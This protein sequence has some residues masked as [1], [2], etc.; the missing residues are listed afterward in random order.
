HPAQGL[1]EET[2]GP[3]SWFWMDDTPDMCA[4]LMPLANAGQ[5]LSVVATVD[6]AYEL[7]PHRG[8][9]VAL[10]LFVVN[11]AVPQP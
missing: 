1:A 7:G 6:G 2:R 4:V 8:T 10:P 9:T 3:D 11:S 5:R